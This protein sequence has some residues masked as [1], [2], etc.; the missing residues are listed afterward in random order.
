MRVE[1]WDNAVAQGAHAARRLL[2]DDGEAEPFMPVPW[3]WSDQYDRKIQMAAA[4]VLMMR[5]ISL[6]EALKNAASLRSTAAPDA[7]SACSASIAPAT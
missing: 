3:F 2:V 1:H 4:L 6:Q 7:L 5:C